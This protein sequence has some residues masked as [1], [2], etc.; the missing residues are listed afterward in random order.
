MTEFLI[1]IHPHRS[2]QLDLAGL[3]SQCER[4]STEKSWVR[5][6]SSAKG[7]DEHAYVNLMFET[8]YPKLLWQLLYEQLY[9]ASAFGQFMKSAS[10]ATCEGRRGWDDYLLLHHFD[11]G[12]NCDDFPAE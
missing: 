11:V 4:L 8:E 3:L 2:P 9:H 12:V 7:F 10:I 5:R 1:Q 6:F